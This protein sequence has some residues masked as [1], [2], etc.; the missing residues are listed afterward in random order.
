MTDSDNRTSTVLATNLAVAPKHGATAG[1]ISSDEFDQRKDLLQS[2]VTR[3]GGLAFGDG[4][5]VCYAEFG[6]AL[7][8]V[9]CANEFIAEIQNLSDRKETIDVGAA[10]GISLGD[11]QGS[12]ETEHGPAVQTAKALCALANPDQVVVSGAVREQALDRD[13]LAFR[14]LRAPPN[15]A[16]RVPAFV[17]SEKGIATSGHSFIQEL[18][19]R[20]VFRAAGAYIVVAWI[21]VQVASIVLPEFDAA[22]R[23]AMFALIVM[24]TVGF[25]LT[26]LLAWTIDLTTKGFR[27]TPHSQYSRTKGNAIRFGIVT[28]A[29]AMSAGVLWWV[30]TDYIEPMTQR[31]SRAAIRSNPVVAV[32]A[33][34]KISGSAEID[35]LGEGVAN[36]LRN[37]LAESRHVIVLSQTRWNEIVS[38]AEDAT[39]FGRLAKNA[40]IDYLI[41]GEYLTTPGGIVLSSRIEELETGIEIQG[42]RLEKEDAAGVIAGVSE[43]SMRVKQALK[44]PFEEN[45]QQYAADFAVQNMEAY[46]VYVA[47]LGYLASFDYENAEQSFNAAL[48]IAPDF[49]VA[50]YRLATLMQ[51]TGQSE[52]ALRELNAIP[53]DDDLTERERLYIEGSKTNF[54]ADRNAT[55]SI[56]IYKE[57]VEKYPYDLE[58]GQLLAEAY[59]LDYQEDA[60]IAEFRRLAE[61]HGYDPS[62]WMALGE[63][64]LDLGELDD[65]ESALQKYVDM[66]PDDQYAIALLGNLSQLRSEYAKSI[67][68]YD[69]SLEIRPKFAVAT[70]GLARS[71]F[72]LGNNDSAKALWQ[73]LVD[74][75]S[76]AA[77]FRIDAAFDFAGVLRGEGQFAAS[78]EVLD[79]VIDIVREEGLRT[80]MM[81]SIKGSNELEVGNHEQATALIEQA[82][83]ESP[84]V[85]TRYLFARGLLEMRL[86][87]LDQLQNTVAEIRALAL[88]P[89]DPDRTEDKAASF[90]SGLAALDE[91]NLESATNEFARAVELDGYEYA[92]YSIG[93]ARLHLATNELEDA[94]RRAV[95]AINARDP[96]DLRLDL[97]FDRATA[98]LLHAEILDAL[99][100]TSE[101]RQEAQ[102]FLTRWQTASPQARE[103]LQARE[104]AAAD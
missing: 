62:A 86:G 98:I 91:N 36:L 28:V 22:P 64:L 30:W 32:T 11:V 103:L 13:D 15:S 23:W 77:G 65:A 42:T 59:W 56:E 27:R 46:E 100:S 17:I 43:V 102:R 44:I 72:M 16:L 95:D 90:L 50:R 88:P 38:H 54:I 49:H 61:L 76:Q 14:Q 55:R 69:R 33:P 47:G 81:L 83:A 25:P 1:A 40:G 97:E 37:D 29:T 35:W 93:R 52:A 78:T 3:H 5:D 19:R 51:A 74:D 94:A 48:S 21:L 80:A 7:E 75:T 92:I 104:L 53:I 79:S 39:E 4:G 89:E 34:T 71:N 87:H 85:A 84:G 8:A 60:A 26:V 57:L 41:S 10:I 70:L 73:Q 18:I 58:G 101:A 12:G 24:L 20:R 9:D 68:Y 99:G 96:G 82:I 45:V 67:E 66:A 63:R 6:A 2:L 31:P